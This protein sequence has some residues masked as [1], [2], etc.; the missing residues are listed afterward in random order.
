M[1]GDDRLFWAVI[2]LSCVYCA[3]AFVHL[4]MF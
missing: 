2:F 1:E 4:T 3:V